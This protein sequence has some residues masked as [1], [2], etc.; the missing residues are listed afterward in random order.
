LRA[1][2]IELRSHIHNGVW[3]AFWDVIFGLSS[4]LL[5][6]FFG[7][8]LGNVVRG[9]PLD[10]EGWFFLPL[11]TDFQ[12]GPN[13]GILDW[14]T[15][16]VGV[17]SFLTLTMHG[18]LWVA[19]KTE[20]GL[21][22]RARRLA[23]LAWWGVAAL[24]LVVT[25][26]TFQIQPHVPGRLQSEVWGAV[27][28]LLALGGLAGAFVFHRNNDDIRAFLSSCLYIV[29]ML[30]SVVFGVY[31]YVLPSI[32]D[33]ALSLDIS[34]AAAGAHGLQVGLVWFVPGMILVAI[35]FFHSYR[36]FAGK[37]RLDEEGY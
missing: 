27:F 32:T 10:S 6:I 22:E 2:S 17:A 7:A 15:V 28:P 5:T 35:Y 16:S 3:P 33:P 24:T 37:V 30:T 14:Y 19:L 21:R 25:A 12:V 20:A 11:W 13:P 36:H 34:N 31:P 8:A 26:A 23:G 1:I 4:A 18:A 29:G 9:V